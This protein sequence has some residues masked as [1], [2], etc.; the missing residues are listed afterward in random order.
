[1]VKVRRCTHLVH[2]ATVSLRVSTV[3]AFCA[4]LIYHQ[5]YSPKLWELRLRLQLRYRLV[6]TGE[7]PPKV[8]P[9]GGYQ[10][11]RSRFH[12]SGSR[13]WVTSLLLLVVLY[14][15]ADQLLLLI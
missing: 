10:V 13:S 15:F 14:R 7:P 8:C 6:C 11:S 5:L 3:V 1:M 12:C 4:A 9:C 2:R